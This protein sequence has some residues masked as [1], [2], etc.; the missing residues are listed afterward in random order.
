[1]ADEEVVDAPEPETATET[2]ETVTETEAAPES[3]EGETAA[4]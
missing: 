1:M 3:A 2:V 4:E